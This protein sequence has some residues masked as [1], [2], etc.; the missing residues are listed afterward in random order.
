M[1]PRL[2]NLINETRPRI[3][4][5]LWAGDSYLAL[6]YVRLVVGWQVLLRMLERPERCQFPPSSFQIRF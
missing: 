4:A 5:A 2:E 1:R 3:K 6:F